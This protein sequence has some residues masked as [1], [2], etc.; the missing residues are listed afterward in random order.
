MYVQGKYT[1][2]RGIVFVNI[3]CC[4]VLS[5]VLSKHFLNTI[6]NKMHYHIKIYKSM[7]N[8]KAALIYVERLSLFSNYFSFKPFPIPYLSKRIIQ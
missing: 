2:G 3:F 1:L 5:L 4:D 8:K 6:T 7:A